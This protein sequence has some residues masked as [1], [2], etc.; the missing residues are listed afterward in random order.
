MPSEGADIGRQLLHRGA[1]F[2][3]VVAQGEQ[4]VGNV[5]PGIIDRRVQRHAGGIGQLALQLKQEALGRF[6]A[7][8]GNLDQAPQFL[9]RHGPPTD[10]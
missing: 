5:L 4:G 9:L 10:R 3:L 1:G 7:D 8:A 2:P 6:L